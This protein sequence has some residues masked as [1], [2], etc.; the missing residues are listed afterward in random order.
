[1]TITPTVWQAETQV[2]TADA[3]PLGQAQLQPDIVALTNG[4]FYIAWTDASGTYNP[5]GGAIVGRIYDFLGAQVG[6][7]LE[8]SGTGD[9]SGPALGL[10]TAV[11]RIRLVYIR[12]N[13]AADDDIINTRI[14]P[15]NNTVVATDTG[16]LAAGETP[17]LAAVGNLNGSLFAYTRGTGADTDIIGGRGNAAAPFEI[18]NE[19]DNSDG[20][21]LAS[22]ANGTIVAVWQDEFNGNGSNRNIEFSISTFNANIPFATG[23]VA[24]ASDPTDEVRPDVAGLTGGGFVVVWQEGTGLDADIRA[25]IYAADGLVVRPDIAVNSDFVGEQSG[26]RVVELQDGG[27]VVTWADVANSVS[28]A[29]RFDAAGNKV[30]TEF[31][32]NGYAAVVEGVLLRDGRVAFVTTDAVSPFLLDTDIVVSIWDPRTGPIL[33]TDAPDNMTSRLD[34]AVVFG[35]GGNDTIVGFGGSDTLDGGTGAD[36]MTGGG[37]N[38]LYGVDDAGDTI[39]ENPGQGTDGVLTSLASFSIAPF[40]GI[41][42][43]TLL[44]AAAINGTGNA[45][46]NRIT[47]N[48]AA[49]VLDGRA[50]NDFLDGGLGS[51]PADRRRPETIPS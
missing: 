42:N 32:V 18:H 33:G 28:T 30:G 24:G 17:N 11:E 14:D 7:E 15:F 21:R 40:A 26:P 46:A 20:A 4:G 48:A 27:F 3:G 37:G 34:G 45:L 2:N 12:E 25:S 39:T 19:P 49:N 43:L 9:F 47:G 35:F 50:G 44:G 1:M 10:N 5:A 8:L 41:E 36:A 51:R 22:L 29:Q 38:D 16:V 31:D 6:P 13:P 23:S